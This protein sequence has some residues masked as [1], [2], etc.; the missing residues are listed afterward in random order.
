M[1]TL[2]AMYDVEIVHR[3]REPVD[4]TVRH[5]MTTWLV[6]LA[7]LPSAR[8]VRFDPADHLDV[9]ELLAG[10]GIR[11]ERVLMLAQPRVLGYVFNPLTLFYCLDDEGTL[12]HVVAEVRNTYGGRHAYLM[13]ADDL[14][15][16]KAFYVSPF[17]PVDGRYTMRTPLPDERLTVSVALRRDGEPPFVA[18]MT[19]VR[20]DG[21]K[22]RDAL[23]RPWETRAVPAGIRMHGI[24]LFL[25]GLRLHPRPTHERSDDDQHRLDA[26]PR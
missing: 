9:R 11:P 5:R 17:Y 13:P 22:L 18:A 12:T 14:H 19:G 25:K 2:P 3:R 10:S 7:D 16:E 24:A 6:D 26:H 20:R 15:T 8:F 4:H 21:A 1:V 23:R